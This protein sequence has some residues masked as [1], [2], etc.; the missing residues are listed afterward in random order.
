MSNK[1]GN[2]QFITDIVVT[3]C[4]FTNIFK[5]FIHKQI[6]NFYYIQRVHLHNQIFVLIYFPKSCF[7]K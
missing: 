5:P 4:I 7:C 2:D 3:D 6:Q 1:F